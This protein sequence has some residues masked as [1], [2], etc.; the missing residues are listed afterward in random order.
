MNIIKISNSN[1]ITISDDGSIRSRGFLLKNQ[2]EE[3]RQELLLIAKSEMKKDHQKYS[4]YEKYKLID[5]YISEY[6]L[7]GEDLKDIG[8]NVKELE[9]LLK[10][11]GYRVIYR[12]C[13]MIVENLF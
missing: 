12:Y 7:W 3:F 2:S 10:E 4:V 6:E 8:C 11:N 13:R 9:S 1:Y 5:D